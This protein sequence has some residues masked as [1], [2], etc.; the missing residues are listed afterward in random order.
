MRLLLALCCLCAVLVTA[1]DQAGSEL[2]APTEVVPAVGAS[3]G[4][5]ADRS[6]ALTFDA[7]GGPGH[8]AEILVALRASGA[9]ATF[10]VSGLWAENEPALLNAI[11]S[12]GH[13]IINFGYNRASFTG[14]TTG[15]PPLT[16]GERALELSRTETTVFR[17]SSRSTRPYFRPPYGDVDDSVL[18]DASA[19]GYAYAVLWSI[20]ARADAST[21]ALGDLVIAQAHPGGIV[22]MDTGSASAAE[23]LPRILDTLRA[24]GYTFVGVDELIE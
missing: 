17:M 12:D 4:D 8:T 19:T 13:Q 23:A 11:A 16:A 15:T 9:R 14:E 7:A 18:R 21:G 2:A 1:C 10:A 24:Q 20:D 22:V 3:R 6:L 5:P